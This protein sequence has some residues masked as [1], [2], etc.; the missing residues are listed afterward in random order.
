[1]S[2]LTLSDL[3][4]QN[5]CTVRLGNTLRQPAFACTQCELVVCRGCRHL[6]PHKLVPLGR[7]LFRCEHDGTLDA[8]LPPSIRGGKFCYCQQNTLDVAMWQC[9]GC[10]D[11]FHL[12][13]I[14]QDLP[15][16]TNDT[17]GDFVCRQCSDRYPF[18]GCQSFDRISWFL[19][20]DWKPCECVKCVDSF[21]SLFA[22][23]LELPEEDDDEQQDIEEAGLDKASL[24]RTIEG[25]N[26]LKSKLAV[27]LKSL[28]DGHVV[29]AA[30]IYAFMSTIGQ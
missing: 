1:M 3:I 25:Y 6:H 27:Y 2:S 17:D 24:L 5:G 18:T 9:I 30:D 19:P 16:V 28:P 21:G 26:T 29:T 10:S 13:C 11:W 8:S 14:Q 7:R 23:V 12:D 15:W 4:N 22:P 20:P